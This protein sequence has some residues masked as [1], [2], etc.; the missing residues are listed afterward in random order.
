M[1]VSNNITYV[2]CDRC[3]SIVKCL[4]FVTGNGQ[5][6]CVGIYRFYNPDGKPTVWIGFAHNTEECIC[7][8]CMWD[9]PVFLEAYPWLKRGPVRKMLI[10]K[11]IA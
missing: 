11:G 2:S 8:G 7:R 4:D 10:E 9:D 6:I 5:A 1:P 3:D